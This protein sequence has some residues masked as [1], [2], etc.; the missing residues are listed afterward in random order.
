[1]SKHEGDI[2]EEGEVPERQ[3]AV[4]SGEVIGEETERRARGASARRESEAGSRVGDGRE[5]ER[6][7]REKSLEVVAVAVARWGRSYFPFR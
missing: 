6:E 2:V 3:R 4:P 7:E 5:A 1:M